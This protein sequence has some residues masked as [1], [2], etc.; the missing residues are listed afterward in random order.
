M[1]LGHQA[2]LDRST[3][4]G[5]R[6]D[7]QA[8]VCG[9]PCPHGFLVPCCT[10]TSSSLCFA[11]LQQCSNRK[12]VMSS[13]LEQWKKRIPELSDDDIKSLQQ[14]LDKEKCQRRNRR[15]FQLFRKKC[16][17]AGQERDDDEI[18]DFSE[19][20]PGE[21]AGAI[22]Y[23]ITKLMKTFECGQDKRIRSAFQAWKANTGNVK[24]AVSLKRLIS[25]IDI[26]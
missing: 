9:P 12:S 20:S 7:A 26:E 18:S 11:L 5:L 22:S 19:E 1:S 23:G 15:I 21:F 17:H 3:D 6:L 10:F 16:T 14:T 2:L 13:S 25:H 8:C 4:L 24:F